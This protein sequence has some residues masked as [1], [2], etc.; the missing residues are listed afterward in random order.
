MEPRPSIRD[1][2]VTIL[3][4]MGS[5]RS[6]S[7]VLERSLVDAVDGTVGVGEL[8]WLWDRGIVEDYLCGC[9]KPFHSCEFWQRV[10]ELFRVGS[11]TASV[12]ADADMMIALRRRV[13]RLRYTPFLVSPRI[14]PATYRQDLR[15][16]RERL[17]ALYWSVAKVAD[18]R[19]IVDSSKEPEYAFVLAGLPDVT[20]RIVHLVRDSR[21]VAY[22]WQR[23]VSRPEIHW[24]RREMRRYTVWQSAFQ[25][26]RKNALAELLGARGIPVTRVRY[27]DFIASPVATMRRLLD[28]MGGLARPSPLADSWHSVSGNP[29]RFR[30]DTLRLTLDREWEQRMPHGKRFVVT[31]AT[32]P[33]LL[34]YGYPLPVRR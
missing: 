29:L 2:N 15:S 20:L 10:L 7:T 27:E 19:I 14:A 11:S 13:E 34:R 18:A 3:Y 26:N 23:H 5:G 16:Y 12:S 25:W 21:A 6:G 22:S 32:A 33:L 17:R 31:V 28:D 4:I 24:T 30:G 1:G 8:R 9:T